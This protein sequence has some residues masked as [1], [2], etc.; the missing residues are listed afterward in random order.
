MGVI[1]DDA[2]RERAYH[3]WEREGRPHGRD[4]EHWV[5]AQVELIAEGSTTTIGRKRVAAARPAGATPRA[6][7]PSPRRRAHRSPP[8]SRQRSVR[9]SAGPSSRAGF[10]RYSRSTATST[11]SRAMRLEVSQRPPPMACTSA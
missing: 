7:R 4:F 5:R 3:I 10:D 6:P 9:D 11:S 1:S 2:I 8:R